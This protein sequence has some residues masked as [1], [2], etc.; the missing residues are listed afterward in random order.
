MAARRNGDEVVLV[1]HGETEWSR[2][3]R[4]TGLTDIALDAHGRRQAEA[5]GR[6]LQGRRFALVLTSTLR[7]AVETCRLAG[8]GAEAQPC[9]ELVEWNYGAYEGLT[10]AE[11]RR[12]RPGW[13]I[14]RDGVPEGETIAEVGRRADLVIAR[15]REAG[16][17]VAVFGHGH[18]LRALAV[19]WLDLA[20]AEG[21]HFALD[22]GSISILGYEHEGAAILR[23]NS[24]VEFG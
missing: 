24:R 9:P 14:W 4:H 19:R 11:I 20:T 10:T 13:T 21:R 22:A 8:L 17:D 12:S 5:V 16:G 7:R 6:A 18:A 15:L 3:G 23:W 1:R 2:A